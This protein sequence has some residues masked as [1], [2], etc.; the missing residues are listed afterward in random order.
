M[1]SLIDLLFTEAPRL[2]LTFDTVILFMGFV[3][4]LSTF[5]LIA[6]TLGKVGK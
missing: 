6:C 4:L 5:E 2:P 3:M 1:S